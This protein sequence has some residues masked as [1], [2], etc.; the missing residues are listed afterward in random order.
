VRRVKINLEFLFLTFGC[1]SGKIKVW[2][3]EH[4]NK[5]EYVGAKPH[6]AKYND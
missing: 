6:I 5:G 4:V 3:Q 1:I 2:G